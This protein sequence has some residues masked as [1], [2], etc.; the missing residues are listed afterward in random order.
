MDAGIT[1]AALRQAIGSEVSP[2]L[3]DVRRRQSFLESDCIEFSHVGERCS[4][5]AFLAKFHLKDPALDQLALIVRGADT[6]RLELAP[7]AAGLAAISL[8]LSRIDEND[9]AM[10]EHGVIV[11]D[12]LY[13]WCKEGKQETHTWNPEAYK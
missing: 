1:P 2:L 6:N 4:F 7:Q 5:D 12:A 3:I 11:Y 10:L 13:R 8:G 9:H